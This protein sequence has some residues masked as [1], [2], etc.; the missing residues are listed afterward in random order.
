ML[1]TIC[2]FTYSSFCSLQC[3][4][5][6]RTEMCFTPESPSLFPLRFSSIRCEGF[7]LRAEVRAAQP[8]SVILLL[9]SLL[10]KREIERE[11]KCDIF[12]IT[13]VF[14]LLKHFGY[15]IYLMALPDLCLSVYAM[16]MHYDMH[17]IEQ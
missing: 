11:R 7:D 14:N 2:Q 6:S 5:S 15:I 13:T 16:V 17:F 12:F 1:L 4:F 3:G 8:S 9:L 10:G